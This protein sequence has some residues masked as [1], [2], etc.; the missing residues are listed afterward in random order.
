MYFQNLGR[1]LYEASWV[2]S[3]CLVGRGAGMTLCSRSLELASD[4][5]FNIVESSSN[6]EEVSKVKCFACN[7]MGHYAGQCSNM[8]KKK[9]GGTTTITKEDEF[10][11]RFERECSLIV[12]C[13]TIESPSHIWYID[14]GASSHMSG[15]KEHFTDLRDQV[16]DSAWRRHHSQSDWEWHSF[17]LEGVEA[18]LVVHGCIVCP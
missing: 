18:T 10:F 12:C 4:P 1:V 3:I 6:R 8:K 13:S 15:V 7:K 11:S 16:G 14:S 2:E 9:Q 17:L 5:L